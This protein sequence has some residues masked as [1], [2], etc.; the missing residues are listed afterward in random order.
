[1]N[2]VPEHDGPVTFSATL[3][4]HRSLSSTG[5]KLLMFVVGGASLMAGMAFLTLGAWPVMGFFGLEVL[6]I[7]VAFRLNYR[8]GR[9]YEVV[10]LSQEY[11]T[12]SRVHPSG[13]GETFNFNPY[14]VKVILS[15]R[16]NGHTKL[17]LASHGNAVPFGRFLT[18]DE[19]RDFAAALTSAIMDLRQAPR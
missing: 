17:S 2:Y 1:M 5:F 8:S 14:W 10:D 16:R 6:L 15:E 19:R 7:Y 9:I 3:S 11:L 12:L 13:R 18:D 4:P